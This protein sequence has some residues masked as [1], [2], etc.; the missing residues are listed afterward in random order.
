MPTATMTSKGQTTIPVEVRQRLGLEP[1]DRLDFVETAQG[2]FELRP[3][4][5]TVRAL[6]GFLAEWSQDRMSDDEAILAAVAE[7]SS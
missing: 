6:R 1:G 5:G 3:A 2:H 4:K 7:E